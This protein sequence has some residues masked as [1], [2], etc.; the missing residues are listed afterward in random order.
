MLK[1]INVV[2]GVDYSAEG[3]MLVQMQEA[4]IKR[5]SEVIYC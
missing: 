3:E 5:G 1:L 4:S 2:C